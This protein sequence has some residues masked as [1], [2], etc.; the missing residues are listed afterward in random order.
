MKKKASHHGFEK[1]AL[2][3]RMTVLFFLVMLVGIGQRCVMAKPL[4][5]Y[6]LAGQSNMQGHAKITTFDH[7][8]MDPQTVPLL[9]A[10]RLA[11]GTP[12]VCDRVWISALGIDKGEH[13]GKLT[14][15]YGA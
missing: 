7:L 13:H 15:G 14:A 11:D 4:Q 3:V 12:R 2:A 8:A 6:I 10:M 5:V 9:Q 1:D